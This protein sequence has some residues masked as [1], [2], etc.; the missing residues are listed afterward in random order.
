MGAVDAAD[1]GLWKTRSSSGTTTAAA[2]IIA[3]IKSTRKN[4]QQGS[5]QHRR[6]FLGGWDL[7][8]RGSWPGGYGEGQEDI[9]RGVP[10]P[11]RMGVAR[12]GGGNAASIP[13]RPDWRFSSDPE[14]TSTVRS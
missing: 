13:D 6:L 3:S 5:P 10:G 7:G 12:P 8:S 2:T 4:P 14:D 11:S 9:G 1:L